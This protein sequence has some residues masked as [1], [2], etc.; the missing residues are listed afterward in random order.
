M[1]GMLFS[2]ALATLAALAAPVQG[3]TTYT[4]FKLRV[5]TVD[6]SSTSG[7]NNTYVAPGSRPDNVAELYAT[8]PN[9]DWGQYNNSAMQWLDSSPHYSVDLVMSDYEAN[10]T[11]LEWPMIVLTFGGPPPEPPHPAYRSTEMTF[12]E[13]GVLSIG[14]SYHLVG[15]SSTLFASDL[16]IVRESS[17]LTTSYSLQRLGRCLL[18]L[19]RLCRSL[20]L[21]WHL[22][23]SSQL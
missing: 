19:W 3:E 22:G 11:A 23:Q 8:K 10:K 9:G 6:Q 15:K 18:L 13:A 14:S 21:Y 16:Y 20:E 1:V 5:Q 17:W 7:Y 12:N 2:T 4:T